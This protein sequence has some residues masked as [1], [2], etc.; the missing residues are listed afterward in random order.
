MEV[1]LTKDMCTFPY[2]LGK[3]H[4]WDATYAYFTL[5]DPLENAEFE[6]YCKLHLLG[7]TVNYD[8]QI[9]LVKAYLRENAQ[10]IDV[11]SFFLYGGASYKLATYAKRLNPKIKV[12]NKL[13]LSDSGF[14]HFYDGTF[15]RKIHILPEY[16]KSR[17][18]D[19]FTVENRSFFEQFEKM[20]LFSRRIGYLPNTVSE[21]GLSEAFLMENTPKQNKIV[22]VGRLG[23]AEKNAELLIES[24][25]QIGEQALTGWQVYLIGPVSNGFDEYLAQKLAANGWLESVVVLTGELTDR[26]A[27]YQHYKEAKIIASTSTN[28]SFGI[29]TIEGMYFGAYPVITNYGSIT[30]DITANGSVGTVTGNAA[31]AYAAGLLEA[32]TKPAL[33]SAKVMA[34]ARVEFSS[35]RWASV[36]DGYL[37]ELIQG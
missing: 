7:L 35:A 6:R 9:E 23:V 10:N 30:A 20:L 17:N 3:N 1:Y 37:T 33:P 13:D 27:L 32:M 26:T 34:Y 28:E 24:L 15:V 4:G 22:M 29:A 11:L 8:E 14:S 25:I 16:Y 21:F 18:I 5:G 31:A 12:Y 36:L 19:F 2:Y